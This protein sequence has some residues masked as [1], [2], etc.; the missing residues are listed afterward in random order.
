MS[1]GKEIKE[2]QEDIKKSLHDFQEEHKKLSDEGKATNET[3]VKLSDNFTTLSEQYQ[4]TKQA[5]ESETKAREDLELAM[6]KVQEGGIQRSGDVKSNPEF[7]AAFNGYLRRRTGI[8]AEDVEA[9]F[10]QILV[11]CDIKPNSNEFQQ[12]KALVVGSNPDGGF[13]VPVEMQSKI[14]KRMFETSPMRSIATVINTSTEAVEYVLDDGEFESGW[15]GEV[16]TRDETDT[17][18]IGIIT[19]PVNEQY[20]EPKATQKMLDDAAFNVE[21]WISQKIVDKFS[22]TENTAFVA[23]DGVKRPQ[24]FLDLANWANLGQYEREALETRDTA[25]AGTIAADDL[26]DL[27]TDLLEGYQGNARWVMARKTWA[28]IMQLKGTNNN[29]LLDPMLM[30]AKGADLEILG[31]PVTLMSDMEA[32]DTEGNRPIAYGDFREGYVIVD[33][34]GIRILRD[35]YTS[36]GYV[37]FYTTK[38]TGGK[39]VNYQAIKRLKI[40]AT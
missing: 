40:K 8:K 35:P 32:D 34:I 6:A 25:T 31:K 24:G 20:A 29:Y 9:E 4:E 18:K 37:K 14:I 1:D 38:R 33:R 13:L 19:I 22:R 27:Q 30:F 39:V 36:K 28:T 12:L 23:G 10:K 21:Q 2:L 5:L 17:S 11:D 7:K 3:L 16:D 15:V 26:I